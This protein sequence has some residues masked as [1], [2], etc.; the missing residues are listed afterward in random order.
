MSSDADDTGV[1]APQV[2]N[3]L[4]KVDIDESVAAY[5]PPGSRVDSA[6]PHGASFW[7]RT[8]RINLLLENDSPKSLFLKVAQGVDGL[9]LV[10]GE[11]EAAKSLY[12]IAPDLL[13][14]P[15]GAGTYKLDPETHFYLSDYVE[16]I[17]EIPDMQKFCAS[18]AKLHRD[19]IPFSPKGQFGFHVVTYNGNKARDV[20]WCDTWEEMFTNS[21]KMRVKQERDAQGPSAGLEELLPALFEK[22]IPR[23]LRPLH[24]G[25]N[26]IKPVLVH[27]DVWYGNLATNAS[28]D[29]PIV[30]DPATIW[31]HNELDVANMTV[32]RFRLGRA[33][34]REYHKHFPISAP[35]EDYEDRLR[36]YTIHGGLCASSLY[37]NTTKYRQM[38]IEWIQELVDKYPEGYQEG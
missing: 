7:T 28:T 4:E 21:V 16:M 1:P 5:F 33:W 8:A 9:G 11:Y 24:T 38:L 25:S 30:F 6:L 27:G 15:V 13:P 36:L 19:S 31:A 29:E 35:A 32:P 3:I 14:H 34:T 12:A 20:T 26:K 37:T 23:L 10:I 17:D 2:Q 18:L 22:V